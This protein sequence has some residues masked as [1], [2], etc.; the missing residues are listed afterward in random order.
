MERDI[1]FHPLLSGGRKR[2]KYRNPFSLA[3]MESLASICEALLPPLDSEFLNTKGIQPTKQAMKF[4]E[5]SG[6]D[7]SIPQEVLYI[8]L[9]NFTVS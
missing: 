5:A 2:E 7:F 6:S 8:L 9:S 1:D 4:W 3:E